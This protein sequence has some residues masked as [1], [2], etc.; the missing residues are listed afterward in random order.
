MSDKELYLP[1]SKAHLANELI[2][3]DNGPG[4]EHKESYSCLNSKEIELIELKE[5]PF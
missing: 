3:T 5:P 4:I 2:Y 1:P